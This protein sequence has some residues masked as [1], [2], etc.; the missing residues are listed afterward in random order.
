MHL[1]AIEQ[2][3]FPVRFPSRTEG[4]IA[5]TAFMVD[6]GGQSYLVTA[7]H[8]VTDDS[9]FHWIDIFYEGK[10]TNEPYTLIGLGPEKGDRSSKVDVAVIK[11]VNVLPSGPPVE[12]RSDGLV[13]RR[14]VRIIGFPSQEANYP[15]VNVEVGVFTGHRDGDSCMF[16]EAT[17]TK[18]MS[19]GPI[20][21][22]PEGQP[23]SALRIAGVLAH[24]PS[25]PCSVP[26]PATVAAYDI[27]WAISLIED[28]LKARS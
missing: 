7:H 8:V 5:G 22:V 11:P 6:Y 16:F 12:A 9:P 13:E 26:L 10:W 15:E 27:R 28:Y 25:S 1:D 14:P 18:G 17:A 20:V 3:I 21:F 19:G 2:R 23:P 24:V 4:L